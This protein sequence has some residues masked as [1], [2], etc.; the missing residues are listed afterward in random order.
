MLGLPEYDHRLF[1]LQ[2]LDTE[3]DLQMNINLDT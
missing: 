3:P 1:A 2:L